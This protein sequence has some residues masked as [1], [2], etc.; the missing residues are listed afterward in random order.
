MS[1]PI[2]GGTVALILD[3][4]N[5]SELTIAIMAA[6]LSEE[7]QQIVLDICAKEKLGME[8]IQALSVLELRSTGLPLGTARRLKAALEVEVAISAPQDTNVHGC[9]C[10]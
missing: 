3:F 2:N 8:D 6:G 5:M 10:C 1:L 9:S 4:F 7:D